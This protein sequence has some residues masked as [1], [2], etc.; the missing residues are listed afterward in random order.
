MNKVKLRKIEEEMYQRVIKM[1]SYIYKKKST[2]IEFYNSLKS[3]LLVVL[4][5]AISLIFFFLPLFIVSLTL[6]IFSAQLE[7]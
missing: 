1:I 7:T 5:Q 3:M 2:L 4:L 6:T